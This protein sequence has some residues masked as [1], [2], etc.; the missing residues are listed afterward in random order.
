MKGYS[1]LIMLLRK[2]RDGG[3]VKLVPGSVL[4]TSSYIHNFMHTIFWVCNVKQSKE[5]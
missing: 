4:E 2:D 1:N 3:G 5:L